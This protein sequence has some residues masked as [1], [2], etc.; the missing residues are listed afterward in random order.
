MGLDD[1]RTTLGK[2]TREI[3]LRSGRCRFDIH[4]HSQATTARLYS[5]ATSSATRWTMFSEVFSLSW[6]CSTVQHR[7]RSVP[8][9][10]IVD[11]RGFDSRLLDRCR[12]KHCRMYTC[13]VEDDLS[14]T[15]RSGTLRESARRSSDRNLCTTLS[16]RHQFVGQFTSIR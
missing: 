2:R 12:T 13:N 10:S 8:I 4:W 16:H 11:S 14:S 5:I 9:D 3:P 15:I 7:P 1:V 6:R